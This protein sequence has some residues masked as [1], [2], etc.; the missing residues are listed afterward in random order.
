MPILE[1]DI[2]PPF[3]LKDL[4]LDQQKSN[5]TLSEPYHFEEQS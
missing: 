5:P 4:Q 2:S 1:K 3:Y